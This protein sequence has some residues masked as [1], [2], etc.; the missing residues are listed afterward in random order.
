M[1]WQLLSIAS[2]IRFMHVLHT[3]GRRPDNPPKVDCLHFRRQVTSGL[4]IKELVQIMVKTYVLRG[5]SSNTLSY[6][7]LDLYSGYRNIETGETMRELCQ[8]TSH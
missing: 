5:R 2:L 1:A 3:L 8:L 4:L 7:R 6:Q